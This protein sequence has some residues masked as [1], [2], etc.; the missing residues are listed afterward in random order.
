MIDPYTNKFTSFN[1][2][3]ISKKIDGVVG[4]CSSLYLMK[5]SLRTVTKSKKLASMKRYLAVKKQKLIC[6]DNWKYMN[7]EL[8][9]RQSYLFNK[10]LYCDGSSSIVPEPPPVI[11]D[12]PTPTPPIL[13]CYLVTVEN[14]PTYGVSWTNNICLTPSGES[15]N[16][17]DET[18]QNYIKTSPWW[19]HHGYSQ[20]IF[21]F[22]EAFTSTSNFTNIL[23]IQNIVIDTAT[24]IWMEPGGVWGPAMQYGDVNLTTNTKRFAYVEPYPD[25]E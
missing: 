9:Q 10:E 25:S 2:I 11:P 22:L 12:P 20:D 4:L 3:Q 7:P 15:W 14:F 8:G 19:D 13:S 1:K 24:S 17:L 6:S 23:F 16:D 21:R 18:I 5:H